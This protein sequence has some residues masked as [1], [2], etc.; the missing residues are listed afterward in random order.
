MPN[1]E[2]HS[3][4][5][6][7]EIDWWWRQAMGGKQ[8]NSSQ[9]NDQQKRKLT[10]AESW[11]DLKPGNWCT[12]WPCQHNY[13]ACSPQSVGCVQLCMHVGC[14][15]VVGMFVALQPEGCRFEST[16]RRRVGTLGKSFTRNCTALRRETPM[17]CPLCSRERVW[18]DSLKGRY[19]KCTYKQRKDPYSDL[20][21]THN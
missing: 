3:C 11:T 20:E 13:V 12:P 8:H 7:H 15:G 5:A 2:M 19:N 1:N 4:V 16:S 17:Q 9:N 21:S 6:P 14:G 18:V 10:H